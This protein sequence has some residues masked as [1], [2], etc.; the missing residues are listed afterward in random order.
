ML[1]SETWLILC[2]KLLDRLEAIW[3]I[4]V[5]Y[6]PR[7][8]DPFLWRFLLRFAIVELALAL[9][10]AAFVLVVIPVTF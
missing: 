8:L 3:Y 7:A 6:A 9:A 5:F 1:V 2:E 10:I 4:A